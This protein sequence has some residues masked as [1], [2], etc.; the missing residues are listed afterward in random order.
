MAHVKGLM[1]AVLTLAIICLY[2]TQ[3]SAASHACCREFSRGRIPFRV[4]RGYSVQSVVELCSID[5][6][7]F[8]TKKGEAC[9]DPAL[10][11]VQNYI[12][13]ISTKARTF[14]KTQV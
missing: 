10:E 2:A 14:H 7:I 5:A 6:I 12:H 9:A 11:W 13:R 3:T 4:I 1:M 8:H